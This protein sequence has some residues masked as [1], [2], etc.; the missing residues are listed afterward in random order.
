MNVG[1]DVEMVHIVHSH[2]IGIGLFEREVYLNEN[3]E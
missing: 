2:A 3:K 1:D